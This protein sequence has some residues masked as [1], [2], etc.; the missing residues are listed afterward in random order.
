IAADDRMESHYLL[1]AVTG[2]L[3]WRMENHRAAAAS[4][5]RALQL[6]HVGPEQQH[7]ARMLERS[8]DGGAR[9]DR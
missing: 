3:H 9:Y 5:R 8:E 7:L 2:E 4:F 6:A 1:H